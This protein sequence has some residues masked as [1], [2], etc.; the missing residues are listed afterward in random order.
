MYDGDRETET[1]RSAHAFSLQ[2]PAGK[3]LYSGNPLAVNVVTDSLLDARVA[4]PLILNRLFKSQSGSTGTAAGN[5]IG[6]S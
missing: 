5:A 3:P 2:N 6:R 1:E 4:F